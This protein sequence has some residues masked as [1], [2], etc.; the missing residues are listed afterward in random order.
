MAGTNDVVEKI[1]GRRPMTIGE[2]VEKHR[3]AFQ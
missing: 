3:A 1:A 2:F